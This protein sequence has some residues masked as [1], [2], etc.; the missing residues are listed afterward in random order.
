MKVKHSRSVNLSFDVYWLNFIRTCLRP[1]VR[2]LVK[3]KVEFNSFH[4]LVKELFV[5]EAEKY[6]TSTSGNSRGKISSIAYQTGLDR[7]EVSKIVNQDYNQN[8]IIEQNRSR[9]GSILDH[10]VSHPPFC[11]ENNTPLPLKRSGPG[12]SF[13]KLAQRFGNIHHLSV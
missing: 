5:D 2:I 8:E 10:W 9:E 11:D 13:E 3:Q 1:L 12:M 4:N 6:I 7:R